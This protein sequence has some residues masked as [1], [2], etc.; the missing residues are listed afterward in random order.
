MGVRLEFAALLE[1]TV[2]FLTKAGPST[3]LEI[4]RQLDVSQPAFSRLFQQSGA[5]ILAVG[6]ARSRR[7]AARRV[8]NDVGASVPV[9]VISES[10]RARR[11]L[12]LH[13][14]S[15]RGFYVEPHSEEFDAG[16]YDDLPY[17]LHDQRP[18]GYLGRLIPQHHPTLQLPDDVR[19]WSAEQCLRYVTHAGWNLPGN[20]IVGDA[21]FELYLADAHESVACVRRP[22]RAELYPKIAADVAASGTPGSSAGGEQPKFLTTIVPGERSVL[23]KFS[24]PVHQA[25]G[26]RWA[27]LL[28]CEHIGHRILAAHGH[29][30]P[31]SEIVIAGDRFFLEVERFDRLPERGRRGVISLMALDMQFVGELYSWTGTA[32]ALVRQGRIEPAALRSISWLQAFGQLIANTDMHHA[33]LSFLTRGERV[34]GLAPVYDMVPM[35]YAPQHDQVLDRQLIARLPKADEALVWESARRVA[36]KFWSAV[37]K[38]RRISRKFAAIAVS[39][40]RQLMRMKTLG[41]KLPR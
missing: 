41:E 18:A 10:G 20:L 35:F 11:A 28:V 5:R 33:N 24:P 23:V 37:A 16:F 19:L 30:A 8:V 39:N 12:T 3:A 32:R 36:E 26:R 38:D 15:P 21:A 17:F 27:D 29:P 7:Y 1:R 22:A 2:S 40:A 34:F 6:R 13:A 25:V 4:Y 9:Y 31:K 14:I